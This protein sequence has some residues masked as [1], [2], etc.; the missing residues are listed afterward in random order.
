METQQQPPG[1]RSRRK[2]IMWGVK[3]AAVLAVAVPVFIGVRGCLR[4]RARM[5]AMRRA[6]LEA[7]TEA[8]VRE[9]LGPPDEDSRETGEDYSKGRWS[10]RCIWRDGIGGHLIIFCDE[11]GKIMLANTGSR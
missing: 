11:N 5:A 7:R 10:Y 2:Y 6:K 3:L 4:L 8:E 9:V 1:A